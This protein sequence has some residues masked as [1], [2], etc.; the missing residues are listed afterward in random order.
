[1]N[2]LF[3]TAIAKKVPALKTFRERQA[4]GDLAASTYS[5]SGSGPP[6]AYGPSALPWPRVST[7]KAIRLRCSL[8]NSMPIR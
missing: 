7:S 6:H 4:R 2:P 3:I 1:M 5:D 8:L